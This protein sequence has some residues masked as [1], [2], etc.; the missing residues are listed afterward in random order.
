MN[1]PTTLLNPPRRTVYR[2]GKCGREETLTQI[3]DKPAPARLSCIHCCRGLEGP[4]GTM[5]PKPA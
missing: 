4:H 1:E 3:I 5:T 2:C